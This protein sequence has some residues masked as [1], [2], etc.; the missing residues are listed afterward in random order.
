MSNHPFKGTFDGQNH[1]LTFNLTASGD[2]S[3]PFH[4]INGATIS[5][6]HVD[7]TITGGTYG[8]L[9]GLVGRAEGNITIEN[10]HVS[11]QISTTYSGSAWH[12][13][14]IAEWNGNNATC[15][16]TGCVYDG[17]I[18][19]PNEAGVTGSCRGFIGWDY[20]NNGTIKF[21]DCLSAP[22][23]YGTGKYALGDNCRTFVYPNSEP[24]LTYNMTNCYYTTALGNRQGRPAA[25]ASAAPYNLGNATTDHGLVKGYENGFL[26]NGNYYT[27]KYGDAIVE[28]SFNDR[29]ERASVTFNGDGDN[30]MR[31]NIDEEVSN[32]KSVTYNRTFTEGKAAIVILPFAYTCSGNEG[33]TFYTFAGVNGNQP[34]ME[35]SN[36][37]TTLTANTPY[38]FMPSGTT[39]SFPNIANMTDGYVTLQPTAGEHNI[40]SDAWTLTG[41]YEYKSF[42]TDDSNIMVLNNDGELVAVTKD[43]TVDPT[44]GYF[45]RDSS[46]FAITVNSGAGGTITADSL[47]A[48]ENNT[49]TLTVTPDT[50]YSVKSVKYNGTEATKSADGTYSFEMPAEDVTVTAEFKRVYSDGIGEHLAGHSLSLNGNIGVNFY[51]ELDADVIADP[52]AYMLFT[53]PN[54]T[55]QTVKVTDATVDTTTVSGKTYYVFQCSVAAK[56]MTDTIKAQMFSGEKQGEEYSYTVKQYA[57]YLFA[58]A[59]EADGTTVKN[60]AYVDAIELIESM[61]NYGAYSQLYFNHNTDSLA[62]EDITDTDV[63]GVT[64][65]TVNK[66]Y[67]GSTNTLPDGVTLAGANLELESETVMNL[68]FTNT[69]GK[70]LTFTTSGNVALVQEQSGEYTKVTITGIAAQYLDSDVTVNVALEGDDNAYSVKYSPMN[71][72]YNVLARETTATRT[73]ALKDVMRAFYLYNK[74]AKAYF[75][76][77]N[78]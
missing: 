7:G 21:N 33:G 15:T 36:K 67:D 5:N 29:N 18:Y 49:V 37:L 53:L 74:E 31:V 70:A 55:T 68:Y 63:R 13:G 16:V 14:V 72:C 2:F 78:N 66:T 54:N 8:S 71:Y 47:Y 48:K 77:H 26:Y 3:A 65:E 75:A 20:G 50:G 25:T 59:Y 6:L 42:I 43:T 30:L 56:E 62:N 39:L 4:Y 57:D 60:Q 10:C 58:N 12:G 1:T 64:A 34:I 45:V 28:Y 24:T 51:M 40:T 44:S 52:D 17:L 11:T 41:T 19:N 69:T 61:V 73:E 76:S 23:A 9:G 38:L 46:L 27:P 22:A 32:V 35:D